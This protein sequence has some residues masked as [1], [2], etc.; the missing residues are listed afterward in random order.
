MLNKDY[1]STE[2]VYFQ[3]R[4]KQL[5]NPLTAG[6]GQWPLLLRKLTRNYLNVHLEPMG[7]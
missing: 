7:I 5:A 6:N 3:L 4:Q 1:L 2:K